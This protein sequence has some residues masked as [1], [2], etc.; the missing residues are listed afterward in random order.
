MATFWLWICR[1][2]SDSN[3]FMKKK[4]IFLKTRRN[5]KC[6]TPPILCWIFDCK[7]IK[8]SV[9]S[10][11]CYESKISTNTHWHINIWFYQKV[12]GKKQNSDQNYERSPS[13][14]ASINRWTIWNVNRMQTYAHM[15]WN[16]MRWER[17]KWR[18]KKIKEEWE[19][20]RKQ[21]AYRKTVCLFRSKEH[22]SQPNRPLH[23][24][25]VI[26]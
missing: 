10:F 14:E 21:N 1:K 12:G 7:A 18:E 23:D 24:T 26:M 20:K 15:K 6:I 2:V 13:F 8:K 17:G 19:E 25:F 9:H 5:F 3:Y 4:N 11:S 22:K 16:A